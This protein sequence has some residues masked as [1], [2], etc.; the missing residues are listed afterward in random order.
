MKKKLINLLKTSYS[1][2]GFNATELEG[3]AD[4]LI[5]SN[6]LKDEATDEELS[7]AVSGAS[8]Y[9]NLLQKVGNRY[10]SQVESKYQGYVKPE[11]PEPPKKPIEEPATLTKE[12]VAEMLRTGIEDALKPYKEAETQKRLDS[13]L[14]SQDK[15]K[16][17][18][19]KFVSRYKL[20]KE[21][22]AETLA[23][24][25]EQE[26]AEERKAILESMGIAD[27][28]NIGIGGTGSEDD[29]AAKMKEAQQAL[30]PKE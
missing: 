16:S 19:E 23:T 24:Q 7:N 28:P 4:L 3:I 26:Y 18:P 5:T 21:E 2:K 6:N 10:A 9:V 12:Q 30:A 15:L 25:I 17:I 22:N 1:D 29:F 11:P 13:V 14:R 20:D 27:I 8:S